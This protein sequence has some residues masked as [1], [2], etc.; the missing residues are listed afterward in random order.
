[1]ELRLLLGRAE[2]TGE[3][4]P[5]RCQGV[6][7][8]DATHAT[9]GASGLAAVPKVSN[10]CCSHPVQRVKATSSFLSSVSS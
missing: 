10:M 5:D 6:V 1:M 3:G 9:R 8:L 7:G 2:D 4:I